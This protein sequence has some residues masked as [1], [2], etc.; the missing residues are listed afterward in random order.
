[1]DRHLTFDGHIGQLVPK[2]TGLL[3]S[4]CHSKH[5]LPSWTVA[6]VVNALVVSSIRYCM[7]IYGSCGKTQLHR[8]QKL[9]NFCARVISGRRKYDH[10][11]DI[12][13]QLKWLG[14]ELLVT[15][16]TDC[17]WLKPL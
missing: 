17:V 14:A 5:A 3:I 8:I 1:M 7:S 10:I 12:I 6:H 13:Y 4:L 15:A 11:S 16:N 9:L 2:C